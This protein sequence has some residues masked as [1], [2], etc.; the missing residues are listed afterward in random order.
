MLTGVLDEIASKGTLRG[1][2]ERVAG[3]VATGAEGG[4]N[5]SKSAGAVASGT[6]RR[7]MRGRGGKVA[8]VGGVGKD[9]DGGVT[10]GEEY[11]IRGERMQG[12][13]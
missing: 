8:K 10:H 4:D 2:G 11:S 5:T 6:R 13:K 1:L 9:E 12:G 7:D 3:K